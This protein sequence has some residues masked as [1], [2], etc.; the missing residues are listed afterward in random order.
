MGLLLVEREHLEVVRR[1]FREYAA[2]LGGNGLELS[3]QGFEEELTAL[4]GKYALPEGRLL[5]ALKG[6][7]PAGCGAL[8]RLAE[9]VG[10]IKRLYVC[11]RFR[12]MGLG[13]ALAA[14]LIEEA[15]AI[16]YQKLR[17][18]TTTFMPEARAMYERLG[19]QPIEPYYPVPQEVR[20]RTVFMELELGR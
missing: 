2:W 8:R 18:D 13:R 10:E 19:F 1:L 14:R 16:G 4:P 20:R 12:G 5:L 11:P 3:Y 6:S 7:E 15:R 17:L 9:G